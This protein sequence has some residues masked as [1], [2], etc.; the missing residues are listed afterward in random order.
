MTD[1]WLLFSGLAIH[2]ALIWTI[3]DSIN[4][5]VYDEPITGMDQEMKC[6]LLMLPYGHQSNSIDLVVPWNCMIHLVTSW[7]ES[8]NINLWKC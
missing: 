8:Q 1:I 7:L 2:T 5:Y 3:D 6:S 4:V